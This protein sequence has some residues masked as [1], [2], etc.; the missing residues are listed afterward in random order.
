MLDT[1]R[2]RW[3]PIRQ[4]KHSVHA[5]NGDGDGDG[6]GKAQKRVWEHRLGHVMVPALPGL[7]VIG[8]EGYNGEVLNDVLHVGM[9]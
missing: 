2:E 1:T 6:D 9:F 5:Q 7:L 4:L 3:L 8:G